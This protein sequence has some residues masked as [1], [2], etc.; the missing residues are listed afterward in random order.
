MNK[1]Q[2]E[3]LMPAAYIRFYTVGALLF[4]LPFTRE[5][6][7]SITS[8]SLLLVIVSVLW[9]NRD[10]SPQQIIW[11]CFIVISSF[12]LEYYGVATGSIFGE[13]SYG[14]GLAPLVGG[15]PVIIGVNWL[16]LIYCTHLIAKHICR[17]VAGKILC[18]SGL[19]VLYDIV[20]EW[21][22]PF[23]QMW[24]F[25]GGYPPPRNFAV[26]F[27]ASMV[28]HTGF[29]LFPL[30][31]DNAPARALYAVQIFFFITVGT[32]SLIFLK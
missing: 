1:L 28:Y 7:I 27:A 26:W 13:Y 11:G 15:T 12:F 4:I 19:M 5:L 32:F 9:I 6:F 14:R 24:S 21:V 3:K 10:R 8:A 23:M 20:I 17:T 16:F 2:I 30:R 25:A 29:E 31:Y 18:A 22:A